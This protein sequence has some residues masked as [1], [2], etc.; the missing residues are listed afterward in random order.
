M[1]CEGFGWT[2]RLLVGGAGK[3]PKGLTCEGFGWTSRLLV[4]GAGKKPKGLTC[5]GFFRLRRAY[6]VARERSARARA[7]AICREQTAGTPRA[8]PPQRARGGC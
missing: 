7:R 8:D 2:S 4:G 3:K 5:E 6:I 1:T